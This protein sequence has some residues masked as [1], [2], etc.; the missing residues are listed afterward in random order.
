MTRP[1]STICRRRA[2]Y[3]R[4]WRKV[5]IMV[6]RK[7]GKVLVRRVLSQPTRTAPQDKQGQSLLMGTSAG[8]GGPTSSDAEKEVYCLD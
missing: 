7:T 5:P 3:Q 1:E 4:K 8:G 6:K 2:E